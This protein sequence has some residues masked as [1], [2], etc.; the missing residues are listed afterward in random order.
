MGT[1]ISMNLVTNLF[2]VIVR[3]YLLL[4]QPLELIVLNLTLVINHGSKPE[5]WSQNTMALTADININF[6]KV[7]INLLVRL[8]VLISLKKSFLERPY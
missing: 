3:I 5:L 8:N 1:T 7:N 6:F 4:R 2:Y